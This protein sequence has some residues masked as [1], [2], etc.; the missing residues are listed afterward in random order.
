MTKPQPAPKHRRTVD[1]ILYLRVDPLDA[2]QVR[3]IAVA[4][5]RKYTTTVRKLIGLGLKA[6]A[7]QAA[8]NGG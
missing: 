8:V 5:G 4:E 3:Q 6:Y 7:A 1:E 2:A